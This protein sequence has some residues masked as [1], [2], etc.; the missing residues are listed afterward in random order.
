MITLIKDS[1]WL[2]KGGQVS[3]ATLVGYGF[4]FA[5]AN[6]HLLILHA[7]NPVDLPMNLICRYLPI[8]CY[9]LRFGN[10]EKLQIDQV[11][12][13]TGKADVCPVWARLSE[14]NRTQL[15]YSE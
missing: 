15:L 14:I 10:S 3:L 6:E 4:M 8:R 2:L 11:T 9:R 7:V 12:T 13:L 5:F 1:M